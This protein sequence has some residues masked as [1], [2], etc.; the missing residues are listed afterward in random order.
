MLL[1]S[2]SGSEIKHK[3]MIRICT[4]Y[5]VDENMVNFSVGEGLVGCRIETEGLENE[6]H[7]EVYGVDEIQAINMAT[8]VD[9][10]L[11]RLGKMYDIYWLS[12]EP[13]FE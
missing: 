13:Y 12:G 3:F 4:P 5:V 10:F 6:C 8:N 11:E 9:P 2:L 7:H 1:Y